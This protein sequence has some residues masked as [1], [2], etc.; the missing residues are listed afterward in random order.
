MYDVAAANPRV[1]KK[2]DEWQKMKIVV[3][4]TKVKVELNGKTVVDIDS[5]DHADSFEK[6][7]GLK[8]EHGFVGLQNH[9]SSVDFRNPRIRELP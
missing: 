6:H 7:P 1:S 8:R 3:D 5:K 4:G 9:G 2:A